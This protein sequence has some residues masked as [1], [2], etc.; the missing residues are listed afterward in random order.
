MRLCNKA[1]KVGVGIYWDAVLNHK[2]AAD[3]REKCQAIEV[4]A[5]DRTKEISDKYEIDAWVGFDFD[6][7][8][9]RY[10]KMKYHWYHFSGVDY[11]ATN[12]KSS[13]YKIIGEQS[14]GWAKTGD[15]D[16]EKGNL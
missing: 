14:S 4:D 7:R 6:G 16:G 10:S 15:V 3:H 11:N 13:I 1:K 2:F 9:D 5:D 8:G 12:G